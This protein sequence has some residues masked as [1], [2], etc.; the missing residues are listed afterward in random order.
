MTA[1]WPTRRY[2]AILADPPWAFETWST[3][4]LT[5]RSAEH[6]YDTQ[7]KDWMKS[8]PVADL[9][10]KD[11]VLFLWVVD[12]H[13][14][15]GLELMRC[16]GFEYKTRAF[17]WVKTCRSD[18]ARPRMGLGYWT[19]KQSELCIMG[20]RGWD[21]MV[22]ELMSLPVLGEVTLLLALLP[23]FLAGAPV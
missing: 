5:F 10:A 15:E 6:H 8:L 1:P 19:R 18:P 2:G 4:G 16:W 22:G 21:I 13:L 23:S 14:A 7:S 20:T 9:A 3:G 17:V 12:S 11:C